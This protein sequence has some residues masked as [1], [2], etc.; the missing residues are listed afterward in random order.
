MLSKS[1]CNHV[2]LVEVLSGPAG[3]V[4]TFILYTHAC[5]HIQIGKVK[6]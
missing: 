3:F 6:I 2:E 4:M 5:T 1:V